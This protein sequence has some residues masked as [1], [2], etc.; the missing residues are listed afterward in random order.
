MQRVR[1]LPGS[2]RAALQSIRS[3]INLLGLRKDRYVLH[4]LQQSPVP[5]MIVWGEDD[6]ILPVSHAQ[7][8]RQA[9]PS[10]LV[11]ILPECGHWPHMEKAEE[12]NDLLTRF[13]AG[14]PDSGGRS[15]GR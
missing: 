7:A 4:R 6:K 15:D 12:F 11:H 1:E 13:L 3:S 8:V 9:L 5:L 14:T 10:S 2:R